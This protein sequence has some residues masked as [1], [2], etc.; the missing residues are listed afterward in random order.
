[1]ELSSGS[2]MS[3]CKER[4]L[5]KLS[6][7]LP[8]EE[9]QKVYEEISGLPVSRM[10]LHRSVQR[11]GAALRDVPR[12]QE[13]QMGQRAL[14]RHV[15]ADGTMVHLRGEGW[16]EAKVGACYNVDGQ[17][18]AESVTYVGTL[19]ERTRVGPMLYH[20]SGQPT[21]D[22]THDMAFIGDGASW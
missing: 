4:Q 16:K 18:R 11:L 20:A 7:R 10:T 15:T 5:A 9:A 12:P 22:Q 17:R 19:E 2:R 13:S 21:L 3:R 8:Y 6:V 1:M 14:K